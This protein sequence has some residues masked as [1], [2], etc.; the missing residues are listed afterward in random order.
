MRDKFSG[1]YRPTQQEFDELWSEALF[2][3]D[4]NVLLNLYRYPRRARDELVEVLKQISDRLWVPHQAALEFQR[5]RPSVLADQ[6]GRFGEVRK[7]I[8]DALSTLENNLGK[9]QLG[10]RHAVIDTDPMVQQV[11]SCV[12]GFRSELDELEAQQNEA[13]EDDALRTQIDGL[14]GQ[15]VGDPPANQDVIDVISRE[16]KGRYDR[17]IPPGY[18]DGQKG[19][20]SEDFYSYGGIVYPA[21]YGDLILWKELLVKAK[22]RG[23][24]SVV[25]VTDDEKEDWWWIIKSQGKKKLGPRPE[26]VDEIRRVADLKYFYMYNSE[27]FLKYSKDYLK[28]AV[29][30]ESIVQVREVAKASSLGKKG[31]TES[32]L[33]N[34]KNVLGVITRWISSTF[35]NVTMIQQTRGYPDLIVERS[36]VPTILGVEIKV[37]RD[38][39][40]IKIMIYNEV[41]RIAQFLEGPTPRD[42]LWVFVLGPDVPFTRM[43]ELIVYAGNFLPERATIVVGRIVR[44]DEGDNEFVEYRRAPDTRL[45]Q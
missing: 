17:M 4:A 26:L 14:L 35:P 45:Y 40:S 18:M 30:E 43:S 42:F 11:R 5:N 22:E 12:E 21:Q 8:D 10:K 7:A 44:T 16:G 36:S 32:Q 39:R 33:L 20:G 38:H 3:L 24:G 1:F 23:I 27:Q 25:F 15:C 41:D 19:D 28:S 31:V 34:E 6:K 2:V 37:V 9:L 13:H 29:S